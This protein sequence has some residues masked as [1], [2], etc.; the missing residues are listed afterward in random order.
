MGLDTV[1]LV[2][3]AEE[4]FGIAIPDADCAALTTPRKLADYIARQLG[5]AGRQQDPHCLSQARFYRLR[6]LLVDHLGSKRQTVR[7]DTP[8]RDLLANDPRK[9]WRMLRNE[10]VI[11]SLPAL[12]TPVWMLAATLAV[13]LV[14]ALALRLTQVSND[15]RAVVPLLLWVLAEKFRRTQARQ[16]PP[17]LNRVRDLLPLVSLPPHQH[18]TD[19][20]VLLK[21]REL[22]AEQT[23]LALEHIGPD[24][25]FV[26]DLRLD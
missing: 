23:G 4:E 24:Q 1:E 17:G 20:E 9:D 6:A 21:V 22:T 15:V 8:L 5:A 18:W 7:P 16:L 11:R 13:P 12:R 14:A 2:M 10:N 25:H 19:A 26:E 3:N